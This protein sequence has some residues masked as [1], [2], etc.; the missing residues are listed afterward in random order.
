M[1]YIILQLEVCE[2]GCVMGNVHFYQHTDSSDEREQAE[3]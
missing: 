2:Y 1:H 3:K